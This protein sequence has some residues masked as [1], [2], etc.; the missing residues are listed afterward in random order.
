MTT[1]IAIDNKR[2]RMF[3]LHGQHPKASDNIYF[4]NA[5]NKLLTACITCGII[6]GFGIGSL[7]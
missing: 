5:C 7:K 1:A 3:L 4:A 6:S 2:R